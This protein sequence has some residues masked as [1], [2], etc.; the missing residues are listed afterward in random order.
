[1]IRASLSF[2]GGAKGNPGPAGYGYVLEKERHIPLKGHGY[3]PYATNNEA[4]YKGLI[5]GMMFAREE[6]VT[7]LRVYGDSLLVINQMKGL[8][9]VKADNI[10]ELNKEAR[11]LVKDFQHVSFEHIPR[12]LNSEADALYNKEL[13]LRGF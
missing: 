7:H 1:M 9:K 11:A 5:N 10:K 6:G 3:M 12:E 13:R 2:D 8:W 4:E